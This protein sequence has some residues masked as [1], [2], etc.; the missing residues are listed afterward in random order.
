MNEKKQNKE[1][2][3]LGIVIIKMNRSLKFISIITLSVVVC[4][5][6]P[7]KYFYLEKGKDIK[8]EIITN[9][10]TTTPFECSWEIIN[11]EENKFEI[12]VHREDVI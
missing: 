10:T 8:I 1:D 9:E 3:V 2:Q 12:T 6:C 4:T 11:N 7:E 5:I